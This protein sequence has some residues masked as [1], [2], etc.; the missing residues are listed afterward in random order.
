[1]HEHTIQSTIYFAWGTCRSNNVKIG[2]SIIDPFWMRNMDLNKSL[3]KIII[4]CNCL[5]INGIEIKM[6]SL[7]INK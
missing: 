5:Q 2:T 1:M 3:Q 4:Q 7:K 6:T